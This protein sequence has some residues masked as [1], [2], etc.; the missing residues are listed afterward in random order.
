MAAISSTVAELK[1]TAAQLVRTSANPVVVTEGPLQEKLTADLQNIYKHIGGL[2]KSFEEKL[3][4]T[5][6]IETPSLDPEGLKEA[7]RDVLATTQ[8]TSDLDLA[9]LISLGLKNIALTADLDKKLPSIIEQ[10]VTKAAK[11]QK[12]SI[13][14]LR[15]E[16]GNLKDTMAEVNAP[17][18]TVL[19]ELRRDV[20]L[21][22]NS[23]PIQ[24]K[25][26]ILKALYEYHDTQIEEYHGKEGENSEISP[27]DLQY[28]QSPSEN[29]VQL[30]E[31]S[32]KVPTTTRVDTRRSYVDALVKPRYNIVI[33][34]SDPR[35]TSADVVQNIKKSVDVIQLGVG[36]NAIRKMRHQKV[37]ISCDTEK[38]RNTLSKAIKTN[39]DKLTVTQ[40]P[41]KNPLLR[42]I[43]VAQ[44]LSDKNIEEAVVKQNEGILKHL[45]T[46]QKKVKVLRRV[47]GRNTSVNNVVIEVTPALWKSLKDQKLRI[48]YQIIA[49]ADQSPILQCYK[50]LGF[51]HRARE[52][53]GEAPACGYCAG[54]HDTRQCQNRNKAPLCANC[55]EGNNFH[56]AYSP[57]CP[58]WQKWD[59]VA[60]ST[61]QYC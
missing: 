59:R 34:S 24:L 20:N 61:V 45:E 13:D 8:K 46:S 54:E 41:A 47:K 18:R 39:G 56:P 15:D 51:G 32:G 17:T 14:K 1:A 27:A 29:F 11:P 52:C 43:G 57:E 28:H 60:R 36:V 38:D 49:T 58:I 35:H 16:V 25:E 21:N 12:A 23:N 10:E 7:F 26:E 2:E 33:E 30:G 9:P 37:L 4:V 6:A 22:L 55:T 3:S 19:E 53:G 40:P 42:L 31:A 48:G 50:C 44:D 5:Q